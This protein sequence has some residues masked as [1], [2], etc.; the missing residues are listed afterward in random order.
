[1]AGLAGAIPF[2]LLEEKD[3]LGID[4]TFKTG[5]WLA[6]FSSL[7]IKLSLGSVAVLRGVAN[8][9]VNQSKIQQTLLKWLSQ[10]KPGGGSGFN[11][12]TAFNVNETFPQNFSGLTENGLQAYETDSITELVK[13]LPVM[14]L[15]HV[16]PDAL[17]TTLAQSS[18]HLK[19]LDYLSMTKFEE[20]DH[21]LSKD[22]MSE[23]SE[24]LREM[25][26]QI[27]DF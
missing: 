21:G 2:P 12:K 8:D 14:A 9:R 27:L 13:K 17:G 23:V 15:L 10:L 26:D 7:P 11:F 5:K 18:E 22:E 19:K 1:M 16:N 25:A 4:E 20:G 6:D 24:S 3:F